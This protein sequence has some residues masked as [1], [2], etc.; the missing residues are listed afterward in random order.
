MIS[1]TRSPT[2]W[3]GSGSSITAAP[4]IRTTRAISPTGRTAS[5]TTICCRTSSC[6]AG[7]ASIAAAPTCSPPTSA[8]RCATA[9]CGSMKARPNSGAM[10]SRRARACRRRAT[11][12]T[13]LANIAAGLDN[14]AGQTWRS[15]DDTTNDPIISA[16]R[17]KGWT[18][19]AAVGGLLQ[20]GA[21]GLARGRRDHPPG[22]R[23]PPR[24][25]RFRARL[26]RRQ[27]RRLGRAAL[28]LRGCRAHAERGPSL[29][30][31]GLPDR[32][33]DREVARA[34]RSAGS[35]AAATGSIMRTTPN[36][37][38]TIAAKGS[39]ATDLSYSLG[40]SADKDG[41]ITNVQW[42]GPAFAAKLTHRP[43]DRRGR[44][45]DLQRR[46]DQGRGHRR[47]GRDPPDPPDGQARR[48]GARGADQLQRR[49]ALS[50]PGQDRQRR[51]PARPVAQAALISPTSRLCSPPKGLPL[52]ASGLERRHHEHRP[53]P[54]GLQPAA[55]RQ[56]PHRS[57]DR[58][59]AGQI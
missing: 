24:A 56:R 10:S 7:T 37:A 57:P 17:P 27:R 16:R 25:R 8:P 29:R 48:H 19:L 53:H 51:R 50:A 46:R 44:R 55:Q 33:A 52:A 40:L 18:Q 4:R 38:S 9:C 41:K 30:L 28:H 15:L 35:P 47:Q 20:R 45:Q 34:R 32:A 49:A 2:A 42:G 1:S 26:L 5:P 31:G 14:R 59:R 22:H 58:R 21:A 23:Q 54:R 36:N 6:T 43:D 39:T 12:S 11:C 3:A 13:R